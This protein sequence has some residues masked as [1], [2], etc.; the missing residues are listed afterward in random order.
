M[1]ILNLYIIILN[2]YF[3]LFYLHVHIWYENV[4]YV[5]AYKS[6]SLIIIAN[7]NQIAIMINK[8]LIIFW[9]YTIS[10]YRETIMGLTCKKKVQLICIQTV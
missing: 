7:W 9:W 4:F 10:A 6:I 5:L 2:I 1:I 8:Q 3:I